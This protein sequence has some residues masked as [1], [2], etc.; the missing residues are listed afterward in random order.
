MQCPL[1]TTLCNGRRSGL[2]DPQRTSKADPAIAGPHAAV[3]DQGLAG[4][5]NPSTASVLIELVKRLDAPRL[6]EQCVCFSR[7]R[8]AK[9]RPRGGDRQGWHWF[10]DNGQ[11]ECRACRLQSWRQA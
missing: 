7:C 3:L 4:C 1:L 8:A 11:A 9:P 10:V 5:Q 6:F 2:Q